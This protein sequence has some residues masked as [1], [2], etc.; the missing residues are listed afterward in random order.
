M[1]ATDLCQ[2]FETLL[3]ADADGRLT[4]ATWL[5]VVRAAERAS[6]F[7]HRDLA[8]D[9]ATR[10]SEIAQRE[11]G[12]QRDWPRDYADY[13]RVLAEVG[14]MVAVRAG[15]LYAARE[16]PAFE[17]QAIA[18]GAHNADL[19][20]GGL[21]EWR[22]DV[23]AG[24]PMFAATQGGR[25]VSICATVKATSVAHAAGV[26]TLPAYRGQGLAAHAVAAWG[27]AVQALGATPFYGT[28]FDNLASQAVAR[29]LGL[30]L[31]ASE[32][33]VECDA[34]PS[35]RRLDIDS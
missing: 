1:D 6:C 2:R 8:P 4:G 18:I 11:R 22:P 9:V 24:L 32:F 14:T 30:E 26:E 27:H 15:P 33:S 7:C 29:R 34:L 16:P 25:A 3:G 13:L 21:D 5:H 17:P 19:L 12:R 20:L 23:A 10:L 28:S 35:R 31:I